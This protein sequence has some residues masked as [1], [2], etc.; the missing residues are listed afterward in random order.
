MNH[1]YGVKR[2]VLHEESALPSAG[3]NG[4][5]IKKFSLLDWAPWN[6]KINWHVETRKT[7]EMKKLI[8]ETDAVKEVMAD[9]VA[10]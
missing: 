1:A 4:V 5:P 10:T 8:L 2:Y 3:F 6:K 9:M 7:D